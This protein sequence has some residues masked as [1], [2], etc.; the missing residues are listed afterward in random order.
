[1]ADVDT[2]VAEANQLYYAKHRYARI[3]PRKA[4]LVMDLVRDEPVEVALTKL[5]FCDKRSAPMIQKVLKSA[6]A[7][8]TQKAGLEPE[9]LKVYRAFVDEGPTMK[10]WRPR[11]MGR[12]YPRL[13]RSCHLGVILKEVEKQEKE[14]QEKQELSDKAGKRRRKGPKEE[15]ARSPF[16]TEDESEN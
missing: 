9:N 3:S 4:R 11:S 5:R 8:A 14:K 15:L 6:I 16:K 10:R 2:T 13:K 1:M 12:A 7:N